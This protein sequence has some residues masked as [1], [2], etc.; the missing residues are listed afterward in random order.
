MNHP[1]KKTSTQAILLKPNPPTTDAI[2]R[3][4]FVDKT[5]HWHNAGI[6]PRK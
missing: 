5:Y 2:K 6:R 1:S 4:Q 3:A